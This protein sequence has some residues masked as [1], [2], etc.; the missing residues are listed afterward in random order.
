MDP[1]PSIVEIDLE[2]KVAPVDSP[3]RKDAVFTT[4]GGNSRLRVIEELAEETERKRSNFVTCRFEPWDSRCRVFPNDLI[5]NDVRSTMTFGDKPDR[6]LN[7]ATLGRESR[8]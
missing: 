6:S 4:A 1:D 7:E 3:S 8:R 5:E 2:A